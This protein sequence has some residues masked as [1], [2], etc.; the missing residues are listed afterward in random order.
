MVTKLAGLALHH[1]PDLA[2]LRGV[3]CKTHDL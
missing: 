1:R 3:G 2:K